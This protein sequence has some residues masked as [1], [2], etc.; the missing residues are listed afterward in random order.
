MLTGE[1]WP[2]AKGAG[3]TVLAGTLNGD[4]PLVVRVTAAGDAT[5]L[6]GL[7]RMVEAAATARPRVARLADRVAGAFVAMLLLVAAGAALAWWQVDP[8]RVVAVTVAVLVVSCPCALSLATPAALACAAGALGRDGILV[9]HPDAIETLSHVTEVVFDKTGTLTAGRVQLAGVEAIRGGRARSRA[10][11]SALEQGSSHPIAAA[12]RMNAAASSAVQSLASVNGQGVE[13]VIDG[14]RYRIGKPAWVG[15]LH[16]HPLPPCAAAMRDEDTPVALGDESGWVAWFTVGDTVRPSAAPALSRLR[17]MGLRTALLSG[18]RPETARKIAQAL[19]LRDWRGGADPDAKRED[20]ARRQR[21]GTVL[22]MV[23]D[24]INDA[25]SL[26]QANVSIALGNAA[27]LTQWHAGVVIPGEDLGQVP[28]AIA[29]ARFTFRVVRQ[30][31]GWAVAYN[32]IAI[33]LAATGH[34]TPLAAAFG[35]SASSLIV[36]ANALRLLRPRGNPTSAAVASAPNA[37]AALAA[38]S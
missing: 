14:R 18:D 24:G 8:A 3:D 22:A 21:S 20:I 25:P 1:S 38:A 23:G 34:L 35:M 17:R 27:A 37:A 12:F 5:R 13:G 26:A 31:L 33:P 2:I 6:S 36:V 16:G 28:R 11:A 32:A 15:A 7:A 10:L 4:H 19:G 9:L 30:N 29:T